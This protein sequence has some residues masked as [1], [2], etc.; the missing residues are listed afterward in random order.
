[1]IVETGSLV[2]PS[3][4]DFIKSLMNTMPMMSSMPRP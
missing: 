4:S 1:M 3:R 2:R